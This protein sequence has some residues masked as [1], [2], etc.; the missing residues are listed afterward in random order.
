MQNSR[1]SKQ[2]LVTSNCTYVLKKRLCCYYVNCI[3]RH[4]FAD[5]GKR[6]RDPVNTIFPH[7]RSD[8]GRVSS[9]VRF[10]GV[11]DKPVGI[12]VKA[13]P[14]SAEIIATIIS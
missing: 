9:A 3:V 13:S 7:G 1:F 12:L 14:S 2:V 8:A 11:P 4:G 10:Y 6:W 5:P